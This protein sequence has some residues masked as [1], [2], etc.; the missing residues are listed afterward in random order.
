MQYYSPLRYPGGK[1]KLT[2]Y[3]K[4][5]LKDNGLFKVYIEP[6]AGGASVALELLLEEYVE[7][8][9]IN[10]LD[11]HIYSFW[12][13]VLND[14]E[15]L[16]K[17]IKDVKVNLETWQK[18][19]RIYQKNNYLN[20]LELG[21]STFFL[22]RTN[23]SGILNGGVIG[24]TQQNGNWKIDARF[25]KSELIKRIQSIALYS[26]RIKLLNLDAIDLISDKSIGIFED[27]FYYFDP[28]YFNNGR[29]LYLNYYNYDDHL[30]L[31]NKIKSIKTLKW[32]LT[33]DNV[34]VIKKIYKN[35]RYSEYLLRYSASTNKCGREIMFYSD[36]LIVS[37]K[38]S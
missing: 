24:G 2:Q 16:C 34:D 13:S 11:R 36:S 38:V 14:T 20:S 15:K 31:A 35:Y 10:D 17:K 3:I 12:Y 7:N 5:I 28:P 9:V 25:N 19:K 33:Y 27:S 32:I 23:R 18:Q 8:I 1:S 37:N 30:L 26:S 21:F 6:Y 29:D 22:N 4:N